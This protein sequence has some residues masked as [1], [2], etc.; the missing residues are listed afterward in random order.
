L[1]EGTAV[2]K[3]YQ[4]IG[5]R[6][7]RDHFGDNLVEELQRLAATAARIGTEAKKAKQ[8]GAAMGGVREMTRIC[9]LIAKLTGQLNEGTRVNVLIA[10][11]DHRE[12]AQTA[13]LQRLTLEER[14][15]LQRFLAKAQGADGAESD[16]RRL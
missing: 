5:R 8:Y 3:N 15:E 1:E 16:T 11:R 6:D 10:E 7:R 4:V 12:A 13:D 2:A 14:L 9:G